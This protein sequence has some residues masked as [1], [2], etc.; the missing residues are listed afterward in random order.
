MVQINPNVQMNCSPKEMIVCLIRHHQMIVQLIKR[1]LLA[2]YRGSM[3]GIAW[4]FVTPLIMLGVYTFLFTVVF[5]ARWGI[6]QQSNHADYAIIMFVGLIIHGLFAECINKAP[7][8][9]TS[10]LN[11]VKKIIFPL[12]VLPWIALGC[13]LFN[14][15]ISVFILLIAQIILHHQIS[16][17]LIFIPL[18]FFPFILFVMGC[19]WLLAAAG[20]YLRDISQTTSIIS[21]VLLFMSP[22]FYSLSM[23]P[24]SLM[25][26]A[27][28]NPLTLIIDDSRKVLLFGELPNF[29]ALG[30][31][32]V[33]GATIA[34][35]GFI[36]FQKTRKG[37]ADVL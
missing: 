24:D 5:K 4:S 11:Y 27:Q 14:A 15:V 22:V 13:A 35:L 9:I 25:T 29:L 8:L 12:E 20:V 28:L 10:N 30:I 6:E 18:I 7:Q 32:F 16:W 19:S 26:V 23:L 1:E 17:T 37:F 31:Y 34:W 2:R 21:S 3:L 36:F 33:F